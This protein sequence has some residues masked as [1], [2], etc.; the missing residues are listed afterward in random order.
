[1]LLDRLECLDRVAA[2]KETTNNVHVRRNNSAKCFLL[3]P[4]LYFFKSYNTNGDIP[5]DKFIS[6]YN[7]WCSDGFYL[8]L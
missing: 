4:F 1:M 7:T 8:H 5:C 2:L 3:L 6:R